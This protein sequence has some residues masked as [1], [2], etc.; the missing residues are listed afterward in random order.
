MTQLEKETLEAFIKRFDLYVVE[1]KTWKA[2]ITAQLE[3]I[4]QE[5]LDRTIIFNYGTKGLKIIAGVVAFFVSVGMFF[6]YVV[7][8]IMGW[9]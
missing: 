7:F 2:S 8:P 1:D 5:R 4:L 9:K 3:P 6:R